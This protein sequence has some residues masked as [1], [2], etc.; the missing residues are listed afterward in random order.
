MD[1]N[2]GLSTLADSPK[3]QVVILKQSYAYL[4][5]RC[6]SPASKEAF[7][8]SPGRYDF[9][10]ELWSQL[11]ISMIVTS[12]DRLQDPI[13]FDNSVTCSQTGSKPSTRG[14]NIAYVPL[15][16]VSLILVSSSALLCPAAICKR[17]SSTLSVWCRFLPPA[18]PGRGRRLKVCRRSS[19]AVVSSCFI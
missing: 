9:L 15:R 3:S 8:T 7:L 16:I 6:R 2:L 10:H 11:S 12:A 17:E 18:V 5:L 19:S 14:P 1:S 4:W 13:F